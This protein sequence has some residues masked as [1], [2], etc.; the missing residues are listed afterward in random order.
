MPVVVSHVVLLG[1]MF[2]YMT[3]FS[4]VDA[5]LNEKKGGDF[6]KSFKDGSA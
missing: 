3:I 6:Q 4:I 2:L 1:V 5:L